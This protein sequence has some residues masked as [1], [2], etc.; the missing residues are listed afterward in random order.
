MS[1]RVFLEVSGE[2]DY[3]ATTFDDH[4]NAQ[5]EYEEMVKENVTE[6]VLFYTDGGYTDE[7]HLTIHEFGEID[8]GFI[9]LAQ[10]VWSDYDSTKGYDIFEVKVVDK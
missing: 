6:K 5:E 2:S 9:Q 10:Y 1:K 4:Y 7:I 3:S 8:D